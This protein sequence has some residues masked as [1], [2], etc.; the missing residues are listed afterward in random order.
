MVASREL[1]EALAERGE[2]ARRIEQL[3]SRI[4]ANARFQEGEAPAE[5]A[6]ALLAEFDEAVG[7]VELLVG[8]INRTNA[9]APLGDRTL[10]EALSRREALRTRHKAIS[11]AADAASGARHG[12]QR[13]LRSELAYV[14]A[15]PVAELRR[16][17]DDLSRQLREIDLE[18]QRANWEV[19]LVD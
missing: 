12:Y 10:T 3:Q 8:R 9:T 19:D 14:A 5:N 13:Q 15:L 4:V 16:T 7:R 2:L 1:A 17:A 11:A 18:I 6:A